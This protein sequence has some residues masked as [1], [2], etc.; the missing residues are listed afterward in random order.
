MSTYVV[1]TYHVSYRGDGSIVKQRAPASL[2]LSIPIE[3]L[4]D[5]DLSALEAIVRYLKEQEGCTYSQIAQLLRRDDRT[6]WT[7]YKRAIK[8][9]RVVRHE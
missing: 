9:V 3:I 2:A 5:R 1:S 8:K 7:T 6:V 4:Q